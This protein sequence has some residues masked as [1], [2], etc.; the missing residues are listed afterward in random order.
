MLTHIWHGEPLT[1]L[2]FADT[3]LWDSLPL[4]LYFYIVWQ[5]VIMKHGKAGSGSSSCQ[6]PWCFLRC[7]QGD[8]YILGL[9]GRAVVMATLDGMHSRSHA[10]LSNSQAGGTFCCK[11]CHFLPCRR[12]QKALPVS[13]PVRKNT[14]I[15][16]EEVKL[17]LA[18][19]S[20]ST[21]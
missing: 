11:S 17:G 16:M 20:C 6:L 5:L 3:E 12:I 18:S 1:F 9:Q 13:M 7:C 14:W 21:R 15:K 4:P 8:T 10:L 2:A 19:I